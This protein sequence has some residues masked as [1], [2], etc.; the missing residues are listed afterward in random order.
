LSLDSE[1]CVS[2]VHDVPHVQV[3]KSSNRSGNDN[4]NNKADLK[5]F[6]VVHANE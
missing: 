5:I 4:E 6:D 1:T 2:K 3:D